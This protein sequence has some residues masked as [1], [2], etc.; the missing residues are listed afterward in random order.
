MSDEL[1][2]IGKQKHLLS[3]ETARLFEAWKTVMDKHHWAEALSCTKCF[4]N[5][6]QNAGCHCAT[7]PGKSVTVTCQCTERTW[8]GV[9]VK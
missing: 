5:H 6:A 2:L 9:G 3:R 4:A 1:T 8:T 7:I